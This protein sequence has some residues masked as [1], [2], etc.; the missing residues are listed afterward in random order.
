MTEKVSSEDVEALSEQFSRLGGK[1][2]YYVCMK[3]I[4]NVKKE[5]PNV[6]EK[7][8]VKLMIA[9]FKESNIQVDL[10]V[11]ITRAKVEDENRCTKIL[12]TGKNKGCRCSLPKAEG[13]GFCKRHRDSVLISGE[14]DKKNL[15]QKQMKQYLDI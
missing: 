5:Y 3:F 2:V 14:K 8:F 12:Q 10:K 4:D 9:T 7:E 1:F 15:R 11:P 13:S 6:P